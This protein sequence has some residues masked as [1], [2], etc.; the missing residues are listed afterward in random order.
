ME[1]DHIA[2][3]EEA[4]MNPTTTA[5]KA[6][7]LL[8]S[9]RLAA[10]VTRDTE[11]QRAAKVIIRHSAT[12]G[13]H[14]TAFAV[15]VLTFGVVGTLGRGAK[16][17]VKGAARLKTAV[18][19]LRASEAVMQRAADMEIEKEQKPKGWKHSRP[20]DIALGLL[21]FG[22]AL[23]LMRDGPYR[24]G[25]IQESLQTIQDII[26]RE[27]A[28]YVESSE[29]QEAMSVFGQTPDLNQLPDIPQQ[30]VSLE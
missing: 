2:P 30:E 27:K 6:D 28:T 1:H 21:P 16:L 12:M 17:G 3:P 26:R 20:V 14:A 11:T 25:R 15:D 4:E 10:A 29:V 7:R 24:V 19:A 22:D 8:R 18:A 13:V 9:A 23:I 5:S